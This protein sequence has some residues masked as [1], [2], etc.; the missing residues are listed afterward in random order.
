M[1]YLWLM[2]H[3]PGNEA[4]SAAEQEVGQPRCR[5]APRQPAHER[6]PAAHG[7]RAALA[8]TAAPPPASHTLNTPSRERGR[9][10]EGGRG[11]G[12]CKAGDVLTQPCLC[13]GP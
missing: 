9:G 4:A 3:G 5:H 10:L 12:R 6:S 11:G 13:A 1:E 2:E 7:R 8:D